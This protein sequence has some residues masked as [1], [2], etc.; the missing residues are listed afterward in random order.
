MLLCVAVGIA[1][2][3]HTVQSM[4]NFVAYYDEGAIALAVQR[5]AETGLPQMR[6]PTGSPNYDPAF[7]YLT[8]WE[9]GL[10]CV[11]RLPF[12]LISKVVPYNWGTTSS[13]VF[14]LLVL[15]AFAL[16]SLRT[17]DPL[18]PTPLSVGLFIL[19]FCASPYSA[20]HFHYLRYYPMLLVVMAA[21]HVLASSAFVGGL[22]KQRT[23]LAVL[24]FGV[25]PAFF[26]LTAIAYF[27]FWTTMFVGLGWRNARHLGRYQKL[28]FVAVVAISA[29]VMVVVLWAFSTFLQIGFEPKVFAW[30]FWL[31]SS[32]ALQLGLLLLLLAA[33]AA[34]SGALTPFERYFLFLSW[35]ALAFCLTAYAIGAS[36]R[37]LGNPYMYL[38]FLHPV[39]IWVTALSIVAVIKTLAARMPRPAL[40]LYAMFVACAIACWHFHPVSGF[41]NTP[42]NVTKSDLAELHRIVA[43]A[44]NSDVVFFADET[45]FFFNNFS[46]QPAFLLRA[47][48]APHIVAA[49]DSA[50]EGYVRL[51]SL[52]DSRGFVRAT[53]G[54]TFA[55]NLAT[56]CRALALYPNAQVAFFRVR[57][58]ALEPVLADRLARFL[59]VTAEAADI[60]RDVCSARDAEKSK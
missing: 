27:G 29:C 46:A 20:T 24:A 12:Y 43:K 53:S 38:L 54:E 37:I 19:L 26:H 25:A 56:F 28:G 9:Y 39:W 30:F 48:E 13:V 3:L 31:N 44:P 36:S 42:H 1:T 33:G 49:R 21:S 59:N 18:F 10:E 40:A 22:T 55:G 15:G 45:Y 60:Q 34:V 14:A 41:F 7:P 52:V 35:A 11:W 16:K 32:N 51:G 58:A 50:A 57:P 47:H 2:L 4:S 17:N 5:L 8:I 6:P 23:P